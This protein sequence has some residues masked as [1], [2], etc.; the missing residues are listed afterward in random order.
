MKYWE[1]TDK[2][3]IE[4]KMY[5]LL[6]L[7][8]FNLRKDLEYYRRKNDIENIKELSIKAKDIASKIANESKE[9]FEKMK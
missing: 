7:Q 6:P 1:Y 3:L 9:L 8:L 5:P 4:N 2:E